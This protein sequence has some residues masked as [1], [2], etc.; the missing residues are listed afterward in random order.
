MMIDVNVVVDGLYCIVGSALMAFAHRLVG[1]PLESFSNSALT[2][3]MSQSHRPTTRRHAG[4][5][6]ESEMTWII[7]HSQIPHSS[8]FF[9]NPEH[10]KNIHFDNDEDGICK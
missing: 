1:S 10:Q 8:I 6:T 9:L 7:S 2:P 3:K 5:F 4:N